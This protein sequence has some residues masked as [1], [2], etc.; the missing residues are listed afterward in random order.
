M[1]KM[2][3]S[4]VFLL[5]A[6]SHSFGAGYSTDKGLIK[7]NSKAAKGQCLPPFEKDP[8]SVLRQNN[9]EIFTAKNK[10]NVKGKSGCQGF[11]TLP[12]RKAL[13][14]PADPR[15]ESLARV[16]STLSSLGTGKMTAHKNIKIVFGTV[17]GPS[18]QCDDHVQLNR[19]TQNCLGLGTTL[20]S[21]PHGGTSNVALIAHEL[22]HQIAN[23]NDAKIFLDYKAF[24]QPRCQI[25]EYAKNGRPKNPRSE[26]IAEVMA[27]YVTNPGIFSDAPRGCE[28]AFEFMANLFGETPANGHTINKTCE[29]RKASRP[30]V[31]HNVPAVP[32]GVRLRFN[33]KYYKNTPAKTSSAPFKFRVSEEASSVD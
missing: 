25:T 12:N 17:N 10:P 8:S 18:R 20:G 15:L 2:K 7:I 19:G 13:S 31:T 27:A 16:V 22:G 4:I 6:S 26:E 30:S 11:G 9:V 21:D 29:S 28:K 33:P 5:F 23:A 32:S 14:N 1:K 3:Y 24:V